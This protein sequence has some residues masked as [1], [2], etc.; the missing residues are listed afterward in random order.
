M[1]PR[2]CSIRGTHPNQPLQH[3]IRPLQGTLTTEGMLA[4]M[5]SAS[6]WIKTLSRSWLHYSI[7]PQG[8]LP[9]WATPRECTNSHSIEQML[10]GGCVA[11]GVCLGRHCKGLSLVL[12][13]CPCSKLLT[14]DQQAVQATLQTSWG[15]QVCVVLANISCVAI[16]CMHTSYRACTCYLCVL[17]T[18]VHIIVSTCSVS[19]RHVFTYF[20]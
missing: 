16:A 12:P 4:C 19:T 3:R 13:M 15:C 2:K 20:I 11:L 1:T 18:H 6:A 8:R 14:H 7:A 9:L 5:A 17:C 10:R